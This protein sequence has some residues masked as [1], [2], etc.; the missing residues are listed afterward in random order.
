MIYLFIRDGNQEVLALLIL[1]K[2][3]KTVPTF[4]V[5]VNHIRTFNAFPPSSGEATML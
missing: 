4:D 5:A 2:E 1:Q 3:V